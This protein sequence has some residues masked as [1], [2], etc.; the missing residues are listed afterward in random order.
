MLRVVLERAERRAGEWA[1]LLRTRRPLCPEMCA[2]V[3]VL[4]VMRSCSE[5]DALRGFR[6]SK[7]RGVVVQDLEPTGPFKMPVR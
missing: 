2:G 7:M 6:Y 3:K 1:E 5:C 4:G